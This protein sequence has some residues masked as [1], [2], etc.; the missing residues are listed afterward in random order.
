MSFGVTK[1]MNF[2]KIEQIKPFLAMEISEK[3]EAIIQ[4]GE[5]VISL[6]L[7]EPDI[8]VDPAI[9]QALIEAIQQ[10]QTHY[11]EAQG[12]SSL[13]QALCEFYE[14][15]HQAQIEPDQ[16]IITS[17]SSQALLLA[18]M[19]LFE[20]GDEIILPSP[21]Y[22]CNA[23]FIDFFEAKKQLWQLKP[24]YSLDFEGLNSLLTPKTKAFFITNP[25]N[26]LGLYF[27]PQ[28]LETLTQYN[29]P[30]IVDETYLALCLDDKPVSI[31]KH[32]PDAFVVGSFSKAFAMTG[33]RLGYLIGPVSQIQQIKKLAQNFFIAA[34]TF[35]QHA[36]ITA[37]SISDLYLKKHRALLKAR[38]DLLIELFEQYQIPMNY[39]PNAA[40][41]Y[42]HNLGK[43]CV[44]SLKMAL[45]ILEKEKVALTPG[46]DFGP[47]AS[48]CLRLSYVCDT[49]Q[50]K[51]A[52]NR[53]HPYLK[54]A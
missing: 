8:A 4:K 49:E 22:P 16:I 50:L 13:R 35:V 3:A 54:P 33:H 5:K 23:A 10:N 53:I 1:L 36:A 26:P 21:Y 51:I 18:A 2:N 19:S 9:N 37:L 45:K 32:V 6:G 48:Q 43:S 27:N 31:L 24:D 38:R 30:L 14:R 46:I 12:L 25:N 17:G 15:E 20:K 52:L 34:N 40:F 42:L 47:D 11:T 41:Y 28:K 44:D 29:I 39:K 7:G